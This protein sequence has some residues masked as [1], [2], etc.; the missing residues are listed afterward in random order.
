MGDLQPD[1]VA[2]FDMQLL[3]KKNSIMRTPRAV[4]CLEH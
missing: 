3:K 1:A 2:K 4:P